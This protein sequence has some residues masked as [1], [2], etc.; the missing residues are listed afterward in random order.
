[1]IKYMDINGR[2][3]EKCDALQ[4]IEIEDGKPTYYKIIEGRLIKTSPLTLANWINT[5]RGFNP[6]REV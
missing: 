3:C 4:A 6:S 5:F 1:M 2:K